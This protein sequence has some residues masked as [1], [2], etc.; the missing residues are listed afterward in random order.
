MAAGIGSR[1]GGIKQIDPVGPNGEIIIDYSI[2]DAIRAGFGKVVFILRR[3]IDRIFRE[4]IGKAVE[5]RID[6]AYVYQELNALPP[7][8]SAP[9]ERKK[10]WGTGHAI[11]MC[12]DVVKAPFCV[13][14]ADD[15]YGAS[16][17]QALADF[18][19]IA[20]DSA[21]RREFCLAGY[22]LKNTLSDHGYVARGVCSISKEG[23]LVE[24]N[25]R[26]RIRRFGA[27]VKYEESENH[28]VPVSPESTVSMNMWGFTPGLFQELEERLPL[29]LKGNLNQPKAEFFIPEIVG[30]LVRSSKARVK[31]LNTRE[32]WFGVTYQ[33]DRPVVEQ[34]IRGLIRQGVYPAPLWN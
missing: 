25:E 2:Y 13:I 28:W 30:D 15:F 27:D 10:P 34:A 33:E 20:G 26:T 9:P 1:Y 22:V 7:G 11:L 23:Y 21:S 14:N 17:Y 19:K 8:F 29:F 12:K 5:Q 16:A 31:V 18:L 24:I 6:T 3:E 32:K 4:K